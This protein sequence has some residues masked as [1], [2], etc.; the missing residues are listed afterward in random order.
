M[1]SLLD[2]R[3][4]AEIIAPGKPWQGPGPRSYHYVMKTKNCRTPWLTKGLAA[5]L[6]SP[7]KTID[8]RLQ[9]FS[10]AVQRRLCRAEPTP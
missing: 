3:R 6:H 8:T 2:R 10:S 9:T 4:P 1:K 5:D 7:T